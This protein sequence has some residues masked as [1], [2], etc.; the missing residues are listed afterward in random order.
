MLMQQLYLT[1]SLGK[2]VR[3][4]ATL[5]TWVKS[6][7]RLKEGV[8]ITLKGEDHRWRISKVYEGE[9]DLSEIENRSFDNN[10]YDKHEG[11]KLK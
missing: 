9:H 6:D 1:R 10:N 7:K 3:G 11:L 5:T 4:M 8:E 2:N